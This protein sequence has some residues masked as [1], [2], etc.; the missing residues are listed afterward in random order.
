MTDAGGRVL[1][2]RLKAEGAA[3]RTALIAVD[4]ALAEAGV[5]DDLRCRTQI[6]LAEACN[7]IVR[8]AYGAGPPVDE[9]DI[10]LHIAM[11]AGGLQ[12]TLRDR[13]G[14]MPAGGLPGP[15]LPP[16]D[17]DNPLA[18]PEGGFGWPIL[19]GMARALSH[20]RH[21]GRNVLRFRLPTAE[22]PQ[23]AERNAM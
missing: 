1:R 20:S 2:L 6:A 18:L 21:N 4:T 17:P 19:R 22:R 13:G 8:H 16:I 15:D 23:T 14:P 3:V 10:T 5:A 9:P 7:N 11:D 12:V